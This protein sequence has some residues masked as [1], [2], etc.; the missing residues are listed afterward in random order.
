MA[1]GLGARFFLPPWEA[2]ASI[3][4]IM[5]NLNAV[6]VLALRGDDGIANGMPVLPL[7]ELRR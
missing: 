1:R 7:L 5:S 3:E 6:S 4:G 2:R